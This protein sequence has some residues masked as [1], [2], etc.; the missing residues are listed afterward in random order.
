MRRAEIAVIGCDYGATSFTTQAQADELASRLELGPEDL[1]LDIGSGAGWPGI[2]LSQTT[3][4][5]A[6]LTDL[7]P[8]GMQVALRRIRQEAMTTLVISASAGSLPFRDAMFDVVTHSD[9]LCCLPGKE[10]ALAESHRVLK[11]GGRLSFLVIELADGLPDSLLEEAVAFAP[12]YVAAAAPYLDLVS[13]AGFTAIEVVDVTAEYHETLGS[14]LTE[15]DRAS[16]ELLP[17]VGAEEFE[18]RQ[19]RRRNGLVAVEKGW[20]RRR[21]FLAR[22]A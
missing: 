15:W 14:W 4:C 21:R 6:V 18:D 5:R 13:G 7:S 19:H 17:L 10:A 3:G 12:D 8:E 22:R 2:Y 20:I 11:P 9:V 16:A 1:L